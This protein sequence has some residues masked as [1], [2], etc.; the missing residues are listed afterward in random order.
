MSQVLQSDEPQVHNIHHILLNQL[1]ALL[2]K[3]IKPGSISS[4][5]DITK[6]DINDVSNHKE[7][8]DVQIGQECKTFLNDNKDKLDI[9]G[10]YKSVKAFYTSAVKYMMEHYP[11][12]DELLINARVVDI[13]DR[14]NVKFE[15]VQYFVKRFSL[16]KQE[17]MDQLESE[18]NLYQIDENI[19]YK[20]NM[21][22]D[23][24]WHE[25][26][27]LEDTVNRKKYPLLT[28]VMKAVLIVFHSN[29]DC[30]R[31]FSIVTKDKRK[32]RTSMNTET[33]N[34]LVS[35]RMAMSSRNQSCYST[36]YSNDVLKQCKRATYEAL[37]GSA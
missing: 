32:E 4:Q 35:H 31:V 20:E 3:F 22:I 2:S 6:L 14:L 8:S 27:E 28:L 12:H 37:Q 16:V 1:V 23:R 13:K 5:H 17:D 36:T 19:H 9:E 10:F 24:Q 26:G 33:L 11:F 18:F 25:I 7:N 30:E 29:A 21:R 15:S 34:S